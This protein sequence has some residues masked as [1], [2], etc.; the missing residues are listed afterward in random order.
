[1]KRGTPLRSMPLPS[2]GVS[3][4]GDHS[5]R[6]RKEYRARSRSRWREAE[7]VLGEALDEQG[8]GGRLRAATT[9]G[10]RLDG[11]RLK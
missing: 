4:L 8:M 11:L 7:H 2:E 10:E 9:H 3:H 6:H 5:I 1:M